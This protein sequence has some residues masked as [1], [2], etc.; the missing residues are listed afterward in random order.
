MYLVESQNSN[1]TYLQCVVKSSLPK[2]ESILSK[3]ELSPGRQPPRCEHVPNVDIFYVDLI[4]DVIGDPEI[5]N[6]FRST[7]LAGLTNNVR[8][9]KI[10]PV[11][12]EI[13]GGAIISPLP[14]S[15]ARY[16]S[17]AV[18]LLRFRDVT[19]GGYPPPPSGRS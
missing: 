3:L 15:G 18:G 7:T 13:G 8:N 16:R 12:S 10:N 4:C 6:K 19:G 5:K 1:S 11:V 2:I 14:C 9:L 17:T